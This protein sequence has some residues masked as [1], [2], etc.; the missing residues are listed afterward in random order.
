MAKPKTI[1]SSLFFPVAVVLSSSSKTNRAKNS[2][3]TC[4]LGRSIMA[5]K[6]WLNDEYHYAR[7]SHPWEP[8]IREDTGI[9]IP[10]ETGYSQWERQS[11]RLVV[12]AP[13]QWIFRDFM[14]YFEA[15]MQAIRDYTLDQELEI[16]D[17]L[18]ML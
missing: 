9:I 5:M 6:N 1:N 14:E 18:C 13:Y 11:M 17:I 4:C 8:S 2:S 16:L 7:Y 3:A 15:E 12:S 10:I